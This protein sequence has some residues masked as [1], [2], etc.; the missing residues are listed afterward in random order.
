MNSLKLAM[1]ASVSLA[2]AFLS[3]ES[4]GADAA[5]TKSTDSLET[6][7]V[8]AEKRE[9]KLQDVPMSIT[10]LGGKSLDNLQFRSFSDYAAMVPGLSLISAQPG[11]T[12]LTLRGQNAGGVGSTVAVYIDESP[13]GS[14]SALLN[15]SILTG[16][17][18]TWDLQRVEVLRGPQGT[19][20]GA[21]SEGGLLKFVTA[22]PVLGSFSGQAEVTGETVAHGGNGGDVRAVV[23]L[24]LGDKMAL[25]VG[26][27]TQDVAGYS[28]DPTR[29]KVDENDGHKYGGR[30]SLLADPID[31]LSIRLTA[32]S[33]ES[34]YNGT[35]QEDINPVTFQPATG[36]LQQQRFTAQPSSFQY[37]NYNATINWDA[38]LFSILSTT[39][40]GILNTDLFNDDSNVQI[41]PGLTYSGLLAGA[42]LTNTGAT[43]DNLADLSKFTQEVRISSPVNNFIEWQ[44][45]AYFT[46]ETGQLHQHLS[47]ID[48]PSGAPSP[49]PTLEIVTLDSI[50]K[51]T[52][53]FGNV[54]VHIIPQFDIQAGGRYSKNEQTATEDLSG[55]LVA[56]TSFSTPS[57]GHVWTYSVAPR[58]HIDADSMLYFRWAT[59]YRPGGPNALPPNAPPD[60][61]RQYGA[62]KTSNLEL[63]YKATLLN[64]ALSIDAALY[65]VDWNNIQLLEQ[66]DNTGINGN[67]GKARSQG[68]EWTVGYIPLHGLTFNWSGAYTDAKLTTD[69]PAVQGVTGDPLPYA[70]KWSTS[71]DGEYDAPAFANYEYFVGATWSYIGG[72]STDFGSD[73]TQ[74]LQVA[75]PSYNQYSTRVGLDND[76]WRFTLYGK[77]LGDSRGITSYGSSGAPNL[78]GVIA[79]IQPRTFGVTANVKF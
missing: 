33:Q 61:P 74:T 14:S 41:A 19:L 50:Y 15:G 69:A 2:A 34:K 26:G 78:N 76:R 21:N 68:L 22:P 6:I 31:S 60:V 8:T 58:W 4:R 51:E 52:S 30:V 27:F 38:G 66:V 18:D 67:G 46:R 12:N 39:S 71:V 56:P 53:G 25:R 11:V 7:V 28:D 75:L 72:R 62:D 64:G 79:V 42:G 57:S 37:K 20:Y 59:G 40:Y 13:F 23:N 16:D 63:G 35:P 43:L 49:L 24:P 73:F 5:E 45:G 70:P 55:L 44:A 65:H 9:E 32:S 48:L 36:D 29:H 3:Q 47:G 54:T 1:L 77:N 10:A 17:F